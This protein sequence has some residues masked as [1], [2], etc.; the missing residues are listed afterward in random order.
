MRAIALILSIMALPGLAQAQA[1]VQF[2]VNLP[3]VLPPLVVVEP[4]VRV[5]PGVEEEIFFV[6]GFYYVRHGNGWYRSRSHRGGW[7]W[8]EPR[9]VPARIVRL[10]PGQYRHWQPRPAEY[11]PAAAPRP[12][13]GGSAYRIEEQ[14]ERLHERE[15]K[16]ERR[17][18]KREHHEE[19]E[20]GHRD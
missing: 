11:R 5:V 7:A 9:Y 10:P 19:H 14:R 8:V 17:E 4:G 13:P 12:V 1:S 16:E 18:E 3:V 20:R 2:S 15:R 6:D